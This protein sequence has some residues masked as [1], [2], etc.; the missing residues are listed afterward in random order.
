M[1]GEVPS[2]RR[3]GTRGIFY[4]DFDLGQILEL[5]E[6][7]RGCS[8]A[9]NWA[10]FL[11]FDDGVEWVFRATCSDRSVDKVV[12]SRLVSSEA[13]T[14]KYVRQHT[15]I[16]VP[17]VFHYSPT[18]END[19]GIPYILMSKAASHSLAEYSW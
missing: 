3:L 15:G 11:E 19:I 16:P 8:C 2:T 4:A 17:E 14:L 7:L 12:T 1:Q 18:Y 10:I 5:A 6:R 13:A 9:F